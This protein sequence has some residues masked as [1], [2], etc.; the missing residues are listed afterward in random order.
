MAGAFFA[1]TSDGEDVVH[2][3]LASPA[4]DDSREHFRNRESIRDDLSRSSEQLVSLFHVSDQARVL[5]LH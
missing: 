1:L 4:P 5:A 2:G 3:Q